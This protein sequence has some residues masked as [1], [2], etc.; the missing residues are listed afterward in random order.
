MQYKPLNP[1]QIYLKLIKFPISNT[2]T[3]VNVLYKECF[4][5]P[6]CL[7]IIKCYKAVNQVSSSFYFHE[8]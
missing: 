4:I 8:K 1:K 3:L 7:F 5:F 2:R 6:I